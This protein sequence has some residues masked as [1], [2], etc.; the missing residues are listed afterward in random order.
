MFLRRC[1]PDHSKLLHAKEIPQKLIFYLRQYA[2]IEQLNFHRKISY[3]LKTNRDR[4]FM[5]CERKF[6]YV[7]CSKNQGLIIILQ[8]QPRQI[9][10]SEFC[11]VF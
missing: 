8:I 9:S 2:L 5:S 11:G 1:T 10:F 7:H 4:I 3:S 6:S